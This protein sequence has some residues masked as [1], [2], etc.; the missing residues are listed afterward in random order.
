MRT[1]TEDG[2]SAVVFG[3]LFLEDVR[4]Y[5][6]QALHGTGIEPVFPLWGCP[7]DI[8]AREMIDS[9]IR[10]VLTCVDPA[11]LPPLVRGPGFRWRPS[12][13]VAGGS[14]SV[15]RTW[16]I[17]HL[18]RDAPASPYRFRFE[19]G[20]NV[21]RDGFVS[22]TWSWLHRNDSVGI[23]QGRG[24]RCGAEGHDADGAGRVQAELTVARTRLATTRAACA[25]G[26][27][28]TSTVS[29]AVDA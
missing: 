8:L 25:T 24:L 1:A 29:V 9:G 26:L 7:T 21:S 11:K 17:S 10:A 5:R 15:W 23:L 6:E 16:R 13:R 20:E 14:G 19:T 2:V 3:D 22:V 4:Q 28:P 27:D 18:R 12:R